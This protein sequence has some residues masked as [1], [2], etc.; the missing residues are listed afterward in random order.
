MGNLDIIINPPLT[1]ETRGSDLAAHLLVHL[2][3]DISFYN[4]MSHEAQKNY[5]KLGACKKY[6]RFDKPLKSDK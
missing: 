6:V 3:Y 5:Y 2:S 4:I 1:R